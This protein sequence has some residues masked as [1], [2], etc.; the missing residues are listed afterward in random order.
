MIW[1][2]MII[3]FMTH[4]KVHIIVD[5]KT[6]RSSLVITQPSTGH[7]LL[8]MYIRVCV[9]AFVRVDAVQPAATQHGKT[10]VQWCASACRRHQF[11]E[12][13]MTVRLDA[14]NQPSGRS[15]WNLGIPLDSDLSLRTH[16]TRTA[17]SCLA[18]PR[19]IPGIR[20]QSC[21]AL[22]V[23]ASADRSYSR[24]LYHW[25]S[26]VWTTAV[27]SGE[28]AVGSKWCG[29]TGLRVAQ[30]GIQ[31][32]D[33][34]PT[35]LA[36]ASCFRTYHVSARGASVPL[37]AQTYATVPWW[38]TS[39]SRRHWVTVYDDGCCHSELSTRQLVTVPFMLPLLEC[40]TAFH[41]WRHPV[42]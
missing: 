16:V 9:R 7:H 13:S 34:T 10:E 27:P 20:H 28:T 39:T 32:R 18:V 37:S 11:P 40:G 15:V 35:W 14:V 41:S 12:D 17:S 19:Q 1:Y 21:I 42:E 2:D 38:W 29:T 8:L 3:V 6:R 36:L 22:D 30:V 26:H 25:R 24:S 33:S 4:H 5:T 31:P 23:R